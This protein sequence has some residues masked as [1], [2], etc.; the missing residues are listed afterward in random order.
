MRTIC[1]LDDL[2]ARGV[3]RRARAR[4]WRRIGQNVYAEGREPTTATDRA[5]SVL[6]AS[7]GV[8]SGR[9]AG[10][11]LGLDG[12]E[13]KGPDVTVAPGSS[14]DR[15]G[16][17]RRRLAETAVVVVSGFRCTSGLQTLCDLAAELDDLVWEQALESALRMRLVSVAD[18]EH[19]V[20]GTRGA[21]RMRRVLALRPPGAP[22]TGSLLETLMVQLARRVP[23][24]P[25]PDR[26]VEILNDPGD[27]VAR[28]DLAW[29]T[30]GLF[31]ELDGQQHEGQPVYDAGI[32]GAFV[33]G[34]RRVGRSRDG[35]GVPIALSER[36]L[37]ASE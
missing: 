34:R 24:L 15:P 1:T 10:A 8:A 4:G 20:T 16:V 26:Q 11:L 23:E 22:P 18:V 30:L 12:V 35:V 6:V 14:N 13:V 21:A 33:T 17:R 3:S 25:P 27:F 9:L 7:G 28:V 19:A 37:R 31:V 32:A 29:P 5:I 36:S 2:E